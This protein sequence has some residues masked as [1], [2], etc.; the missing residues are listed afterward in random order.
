MKWAYGFVAM[1]MTAFILTACGELEEPPTTEAPIVVPASTPTPVATPA[2]ADG[3]EGR[4]G[5]SSSSEDTDAKADGDGTVPDKPTDD[6]STVSRQNPG[7]EGTSFDFSVNDP[8]QDAD[9]LDLVSWTVEPTISAGA[10]EAEGNVE[11]GAN[12]FNPM[13]DGEGAGFAVYFKGNDEPMVVL[14]PDLGPTRIWETDL[15]VADMEHEYE[16][17]EFTFRAYSP[18]FMDVGP[19]DLEMRVFGYLSDGSHAVLAARDIAVP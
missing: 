1:L 12:I 9:P 13:F 3:S 14:L 11:D 18:L 5:Q 7:F 2:T 15:T 17:G 4:S 10:L 16:A 8:L 19:S 6:D